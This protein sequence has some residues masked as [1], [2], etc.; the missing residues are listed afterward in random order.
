MI[1]NLQRLPPFQRRLVFILIL[2]GGLMALIAITAILISL[3]VNGRRAEAVAVDKTLTV[4]QFAALPDKDAYPAAVTVGPDGTVY[5]ASFATGAIWSINGKGETH[6]IPFTR[7]EIGAVSGL[8][9]QADG[10]IL[11]VDQNDT[12]PRSAGGEVKRVAPDGK[13]TT[14]AVPTDRKDFVSPYDIEQDKAG[15]VYVTDRGR[16]QVWRF[17]ADG[18]NGIDWWSPTIATGQPTGAITGL[19]YDAVTDTMVVT[20]P[21]TD[22]LY[23]VTIADA[24]S[25]V[26]YH[27]TQTAEDP[28]GP[29][30]NGATFGPNSTLYLA[31]LGRNTLVTLQDGKLVTLVASFRGISD[32]AFAV[33]NKLYVTNF[34]Q[35]SLV[36]P[37]VQPRLPFALDM[38]T[39][40]SS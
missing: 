16:N 17:N 1:A 20:D 22:T 7:D 12:D 32:V 3:T 21:D 8:T 29:G 23:R 33:P 37:L 2:V 11:A 31:A 26:I 9:I 4:A 6:E 24:K 34:D 36:V 40:P 5:T 18:S 27:F 39:L 13:I 35:S 30:F 38:V 19:A 15:H 28:I 14:F 10:S 25:E